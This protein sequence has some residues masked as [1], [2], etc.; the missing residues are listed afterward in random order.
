ME[1]CKFPGCN[2]VADFI[3][4]A[5]CRIEHGMER[6]EVEKLYGQSHP[7]K[8]KFSGKIDPW[9]PTD[10]QIFEA[11]LNGINKKTLFERARRGWEVEAALKVPIF[12]KE[13]IARIGARAQGFNIMTG[14]FTRE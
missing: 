2:Y 6:S 11:E 8:V 4:K 1:R 10:K 9:F 3:S 14:V 5:H 12:T 7:T 13:E